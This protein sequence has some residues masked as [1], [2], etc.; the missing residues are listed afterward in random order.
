MFWLNPF[1]FVIKNLLIKSEFTVAKIKSRWL[2]IVGI[3][4]LFVGLG[5][6]LISVLDIFGTSITDF[7]EWDLMAP[8][9]GFAPMVAPV[10]AGDQ[11][12]IAPDIKSN[13]LQLTGTLEVTPQMAESTQ[14]PIQTTVP[15]RVALRPERIII[16]SIQLDAP[17]VPSKPK[18][19]KIGGKSYEQWQAPNK[20]AVGWQTDSVYIGQIGNTVLNGHHNVDGKVFEHLNEVEAG[21][22]I[23]IAGSTYQYEYR[24]VNVMIFPER[25]VDVKTRL[26][27][28]RWIL[29]ST[30]ERVTLVTC[31]P[32]WSNTHRLIVVA[33]P[34]GDPQPVETPAPGR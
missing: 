24:V 9:E 2:I 7:S 22:K 14:N 17:I 25:D 11:K 1:F 19:T 29:P 10:Q 20:F 4:L 32:A 16:P 5:G 12:E 8:K 23:I 26:E 33:Q 15:T 21:D 13:I 31:W 6:T 28:A 27:N 34:I 18:E 30:D 3:V